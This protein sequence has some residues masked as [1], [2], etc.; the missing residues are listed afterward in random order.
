MEFALN[1]LRKNTRK[2]FYGAPMVTEWITIREALRTW[3]IAG[4]CA[5]PGGP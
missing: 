4:K 5:G 2:K 3:N 1:S